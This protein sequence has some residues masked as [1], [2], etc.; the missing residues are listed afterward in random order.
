MTVHD[1]PNERALL[2]PASHARS[3]LLF[4]LPSELITKIFELALLGSKPSDLSALSKTIHNYVNDI[5]YRVVVLDSAHSIRLFHRTA[6]SNQQVLSY[7]KK[8]V[9]TW[10]SDS[11]YLNLSKEIRG[12]IAECTQIHTLE[13]PILEPE[14]MA[15]FHWHPNLIEITT[16]YMEADIGQFQGKLKSLW[17][18]LTH[19]RLAEPAEF[20]WKRPADALEEFGN[21]PQL[22]YLQLSRRANANQENDLIFVDDVQSILQGGE[23]PSLKVLIVSVIEGNDTWKPEPVRESNI[24]EMLEEVARQDKR[25]VL[26][27]GKYGEWATGWKDFRPIDGG[28]ASEFWK[29]YGVKTVYS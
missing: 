2:K 26:V 21:P 6:R 19:L 9:I 28:M 25:L 29:E 10:Q 4:E 12:I 24:W 16:R 5:L 7:V 22:A 11:A 20:G 1:A 18:K 8:L 27:E 14:A 3:S 15:D 17:D 23:F 13:I